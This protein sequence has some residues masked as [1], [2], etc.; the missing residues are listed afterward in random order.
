LVRLNVESRG[1]EKLMNNK[2]EEILDLIK[3]LS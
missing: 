1:D 3:N 2:T